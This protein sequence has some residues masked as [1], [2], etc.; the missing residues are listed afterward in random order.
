MKKSILN[1]GKTLDKL[2]QQQ[3]SGG[4]IVNCMHYRICPP[5]D[6][7]ACKIIDNECILLG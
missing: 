2:E 4:K 7:L 3:I 5:I 6:E 1:L